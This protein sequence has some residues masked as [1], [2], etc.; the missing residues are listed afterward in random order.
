MR[1]WTPQVKTTLIEDSDDDDDDH[2][3]I[4]LE[5]STIFKHVNEPNYS[6]KYLQ[7]SDMIKI[8]ASHNAFSLHHVQGLCQTAGNVN[9]RQRFNLD[10]GV[11]G[12]CAPAPYLSSETLR[13]E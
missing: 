8:N 13:I 11:T 2:F 4:A 7:S 9:F 12:I 3:K 10:P 5:P 1:K 6:P